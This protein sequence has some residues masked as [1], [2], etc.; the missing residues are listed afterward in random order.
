[1][2]AVGPDRRG[3]VVHRERA[4]RVGQHVADER[5]GLEDERDAVV[6]EREARLAVERREVRAA[7]QREGHL[8][9]P[10]EAAQA[11]VDVV[12]ER[13]EDARSAARRDSVPLH[14]VAGEQD[15][16]RL[17][18]VGA[19]SARVPARLHDAEAASTGLEHVTVAQD[20]IDRKVAAAHRDDLVVDSGDRHRAGEAIPE[21]VP[22]A[23]DGLDPDHVLERGR[24][25]ERRVR[26][27]GPGGRPCGR[28]GR[29]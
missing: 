15:A 18:E 19:V 27:A 14:R 7:E 5:V 29:A 9:Q 25:G 26:A 2:P 28:G 4:S 20:A 22:L 1:M 8:A 11:V 10:R 13:R 3:H 24:D 17:L 23:L 6:E 12:V 21:V 16:G